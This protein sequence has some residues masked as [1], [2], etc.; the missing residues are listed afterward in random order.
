MAGLGTNVSTNHAVKAQMGGGIML[1]GQ[2]RQVWFFAPQ[3]AAPAQGFMGDRQLPSCIMEFPSGQAC[4]VDFLNDSFMPHT[5][6]LHG[7][8]VDMAN[9]GV[10]QTSGTVGGSGTFQY[11]FTA[12]H[13]GTYMYHCHV[14]TIIHFAKGMYGMI[15][16]RPSDGAT[17]RA[18]DG[19]PTFDEEVAWHLHTMDTS[20]DGFFGSQPG[21][22]RYHPDHFLLNGKETV[23]ATADPYTK[24]VVAQGGKAYIRAM[25][26]G[27]NWARISMGGL[28]FE[29][30]AS[31][32]RPMQ[33]AV[34][35]CVWEVGPGER[36]DL[37]V[38]AGRPGT[39][40]AQVDYLDDYSGAVLGSVQTVV[41]FV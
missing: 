13:P 19:G 34:T 31:D 26:V 7:M 11:Q 40:T 33:Q 29:V 3:G 22:A 24:V 23:D 28:P 2:N 38:S 25:N 6:H 15:I 32:G 27:Y 14:D 36:Y 35:A 1:G 9:D 5:I 41:Q 10:P 20:W 17:D 37:L 39:Y 21:N 16:V 18:W 12:P 4:T 30:V 8:D